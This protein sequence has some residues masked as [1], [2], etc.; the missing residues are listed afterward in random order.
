MTTAA[1]RARRSE[2]ATPASSEKMC[3]KTPTSG[4]DLVFLDLE[5]ACA[6]LAKVGARR[7]A[8]DALTGQDWGRTLRA[9][10]VNGLDTQW[11]HDD[12]IDIVRPSGG[13][14]SS[15]ERSTPKRRENGRHTVPKPGTR[16]RIRPAQPRARYVRTT[17]SPERARSF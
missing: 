17:R 11:C 13:I 5:D 16:A 14:S 15:V 9:V 4:A 10:R 8:I 7:T 3:A 1:P 2:L 12:I 6:P